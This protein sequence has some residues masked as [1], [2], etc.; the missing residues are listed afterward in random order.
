MN[1]LILDCSQD[2]CSKD[3][4][5]DHIIAYNIKNYSNFEAEAV[6]PSEFINKIC[7]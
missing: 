4:C 6:T 5:A 2:K 7:A 1:S 3:V